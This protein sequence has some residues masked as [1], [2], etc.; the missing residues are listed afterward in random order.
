MTGSHGHGYNVLAYTGDTD[1]DARVVAEHL[2][3]ANEVKALVATTALGMGYDKPDL[4]FV[5]HYQAPGSPVAYYQQVGRAGRALAA[6]VAV[7]LV[8][9]EDRAIQDYFIERAFPSAEQVDEVLGVLDRYSGPVTVSLVEEQVNLRRTDIVLILKQLDVEGVVRRVGGLRFERTLK[10]WA[11]PTDRVERVTA[12][13]R[14]EQT[15]MLEYIDTA[16]CR[17]VYLTQLLDDRTGASCGICDRCTGQKVGRD[18]TIELRVQ[19]ERFLL[20]RPLVIEPRHH[21]VPKEHRCEPGRALARWGSGGWGPMIQ[22]GKHS[23]EFD[24]QL[25]DALADLV[26]EWSPTPAPEWITAVPSLRH[27]KLVD[28]LAHR[29][30]D[31]LRLP[32]RPVVRKVS[33]RPPQKTR[34]NG[35]QQ[36][37]NVRDAFAIDGDVLGTAVLL[38]DDLVDSRWTFAEVGK[39]LRAGG[40]G[41][42]Y[43]VALASTAG[44]S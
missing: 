38:V 2:L 39:A 9:S 6:S 26:R 17:M 10:E 7:L 23:G 11:Y 36:R 3:Q 37:A 43:P 27:P 22:A 16:M 5:V 33:E 19:A 13:R 20:R 4:G 29:L 30:A 31:R 12:A 42:V 21:G 41:P 25:V 28:S 18:T 40:T 8:G 24:D 32:H 1:G 14:K 44:R 15:Q 35:A 34:E